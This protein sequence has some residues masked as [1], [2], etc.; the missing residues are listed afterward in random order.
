MDT[1]RSDSYYKS[2]EVTYTITQTPLAFT[3]VQKF[4]LKGSEESIT[5]DYTF[6]LDGKITT[7]KKESGTEKELALW[8]DDKRS[9]IT[10]STITYGAEE[11]GFTE[12]Y[13]LS[14]DGLVLTAEKSNIIPGGLTVKQV[15]NKK[16]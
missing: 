1:T 2:F 8:S 5:N 13:S 11:V 15:F 6:S 4:A 7:M 10:R 3:V 12:T 16:P 9:L 14:G